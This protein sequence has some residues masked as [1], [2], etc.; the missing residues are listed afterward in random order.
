MSKTAFCGLAFAAALALPAAPAR[1][2]QLCGWLVE[3]VDAEQ[4]H[5]F[6]LWLESDADLEFFYKMS[7]K[8]IVTPSMKAYSPGKGTFTLHPKRPDKP[9]S[10]GTTIGDEGDVDIVAEIHVM[11]KSIFDETETPLLAKF[12]FQRHVPE[13]EKTPPGEFAKHQCVTVPNQPRD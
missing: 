1:A 6:A 11:P 12:V 4:T 8:G 5:D 10:F 3:T 13:D 2:A 7:G 9:W